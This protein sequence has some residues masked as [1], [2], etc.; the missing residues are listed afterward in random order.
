MLRIENL[1]VAYNEILALKGISLTVNEGEVVT[2]IGAN[3]AGKSTTLKTISGLLKPRTGTIEFKGK[4]LQSLMPD[5]IVAL[6]II[7]VPEGRRIFGELTVEE[8]LKVGAHLIRELSELKK[9]LERVYHLFPKLRERR[10]QRGG[11]LSGG[12]QQMLAFG[13]AMMSN[14]RLLLLDEPSLGLAPLLVEEVAQ[15]IARF[16][17]ENITVLLVEQNAQLAL[18]LANRG[19]VLETGIIVLSDTAGNLLKSPLIQM[20]YL[21]KTHS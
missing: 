16:K 21:G 4:G 6:G 15:V 20:S 12:E 3:G 13:R 10:S 19:Y 7:H 1:I 17:H 14:P 8:N 2:L 9:T 5:Q 18:S 11:T